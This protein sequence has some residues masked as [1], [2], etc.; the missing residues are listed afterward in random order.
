MQKTISLISKK[1]RL[2]WAA[3]EISKFQ[4]WSILTNSRRRYMA[5]ILPIRHKTLSNQSFNQLTYIDDGPTLPD[6]A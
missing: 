5:E 3:R 2:V 4:N 6:D 1:S